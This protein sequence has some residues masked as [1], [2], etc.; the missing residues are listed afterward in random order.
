[1][2]NGPPRSESKTVPPPKGAKD[3]YSAPTRVGTL[4]EEILAAL[5]QRE[6]TDVAPDARTRSGTMPVMRATVPSVDVSA[7]ESDGV[8]HAEHDETDLEG[9]GARLAPTH[10]S[11]TRTLP[12]PP[13]STPVQ[14]LAPPNPRAPR[15]SVPPPP[16]VPRFSEPPSAP[17]GTFAYS[18]RVSPPPPAA[19][20]APPQEIVV[21]LPDEPRP[22]V[23]RSI[24]IV[25]IFALLGGA[26]AAAIVFW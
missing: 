23:V 6:V 17:P 11:Q 9:S 13:R 4:P 12:P 2:S 16:G 22:S 14:L 10:H 25:A 5:R 24:A 18:Q 3:A 20:P 19:W 1:M 15:V 26:V 7:F 8:E 21:E